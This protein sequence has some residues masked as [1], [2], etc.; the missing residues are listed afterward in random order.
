MGCIFLKGE[1]QKFCTAYAE[2]M[3]LS[4]EELKKFCE[5]P[6]YHL[7][8]VYQKFEKSGEKIPVCEH[9]QFKNFAGI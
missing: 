7:C 6:H 5:S 4:L 2:V 9:T 3:V 1:C 8:S